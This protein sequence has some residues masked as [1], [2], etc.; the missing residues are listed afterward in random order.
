MK[1]EKL[2]EQLKEQHPY[3]DDI[4]I[5][6]TKKQWEAFHKLLSESGMLSG[7]FIGAACRVGYNACIFQ[8]E[9]LES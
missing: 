2:I 6:P 3:P 9:K 7:G 4:F 1:P 5:E 8:I